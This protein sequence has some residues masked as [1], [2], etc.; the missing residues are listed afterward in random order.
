MELKTLWT[1]SDN[2]IALCKV[3]DDG[4]DN[5]IKHDAIISIPRLIEAIDIAKLFSEFNYLSISLIKLRA[6][7]GDVHN[8]LVLTPSGGLPESQLCVLLAPMIEKPEE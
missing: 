2:I 4:I 8:L 6:K 5:S 7:T 1:T 3:T